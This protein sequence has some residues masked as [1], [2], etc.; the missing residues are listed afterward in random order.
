MANV[1]LDLERLID[2][3]EHFFHSLWGFYCPIKKIKT[4]YPILFMGE[5]LDGGEVI[6]TPPFCP[7]CAGK[8]E[9]FL[10]DPNIPYTFHVTM[11][12]VK[13]VKK[14]ETKKP[15]QQPQKRSP[16][17][18]HNGEDKFILYLK[19]TLSFGKYKH[20]GQTV[21]DLIDLDPDYLDWVEENVD[22][23]AFSE[24][25]IL[26]RKDRDGFAGEDFLGIGEDSE[27]PF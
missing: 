7:F 13:K 18:K 20:S 3:G 26:A 2:Q 11:A 8:I 25:V 12:A 14:P 27:L 24:E 22:W 23:V 6:D 21:A 4:M 10:E 19:S 9:E 15:P 17:P 1:L 5:S 16:A